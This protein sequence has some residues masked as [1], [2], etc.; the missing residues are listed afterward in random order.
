MAP[1]FS[2]EGYLPPGVHRWEWST[3]QVAFGWTSRRRHLLGG[4][5]L[6]LQALRIASC[7]RIFVD[8]SFVTNKERPDDYDACWDITG[9]DVRKLDPI[10]LTFDSGRAAQKVKFR[11]EL[12]PAN[13][14]ADHAS[15]QRYLEFFQ[16]DLDGRPKGIVEI[17][18]G[19]S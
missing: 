7:R 6:A 15:G 10:L 11:G 14:I 17:N 18:L 19:H 2:K 4:M 13:F 1:D 8:G 9:V 5:A 3:F 12:F 16:Q